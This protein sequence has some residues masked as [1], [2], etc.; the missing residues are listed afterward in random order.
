MQ[1][2]CFWINITYILGEN[3][4]MSTKYLIKKLKSSKDVAPKQ[5][6]PPVIKQ[7]KISKGQTVEGAIQEEVSEIT[8]KN[9]VKSYLDSEIKRLRKQ[10]VTI[11]ENIDAVTSNMEILMVAQ[12][13]I[14]EFI[15]ELR[16]VK[17]K[18]PSKWKRLFK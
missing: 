14:L 5:L 4:C 9:P 11:E 1:S 8:S 2:N 18:K 7:V 12:R 15:E 16:K 6:K 3:N 10:L 13:E 17:K